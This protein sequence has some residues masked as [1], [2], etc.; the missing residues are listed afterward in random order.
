MAFSCSVAWGGGAVFAV[1]C[2]FLGTWFPILQTK[3]KFM[4]FI[5][6]I[7]FNLKFLYTKQKVRTIHYINWSYVTVRIEQLHIRTVDPWPVSSLTLLVGMF[8]DFRRL[9]FIPDLL[10]LILGMFFLVVLGLMLLGI[11]LWV[12]LWLFVLL[13][14]VP[15]AV[16]YYHNK[17]NHCPR[18]SQNAS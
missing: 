7:G 17:N 1:Y 12:F 5:F 10:F 3:S 2:D 4:W 15:F 8:I 18:T 14:S 9:V 13:V 6:Q 16:V 11:G